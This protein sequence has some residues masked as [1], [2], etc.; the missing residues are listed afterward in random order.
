MKRSAL[1][2]SWTKNT[3]TVAALIALGGFLA[4]SL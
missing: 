3:K 2:T 1:S 4:V